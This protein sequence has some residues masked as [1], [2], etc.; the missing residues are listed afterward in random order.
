MFRFSRRWRRFSVLFLLSLTFWLLLETRLVAVVKTDTNVVVAKFLPRIKTKAEPWEIRSQV[1]P[2]NESNESNEG[3]ASIMVQQGLRLYQS[4]K[5]AEAINVWQQA[6]GVISNRLDVALVRNNLA[7]AYRQIGNLNEAVQQWDQAIEIYRLPNNEATQERLAQ[8]LV[9][10]GQTY[11]DLGQQQRAIKLFQ[12]ALEIAKTNNLQ[13]TE[14]AALGGLGNAYWAGGN[15]EQAISACEASLRIARELN[16][17]GKTGKYYIITALNNLGN[18][19]A[20]R[21]ERYRISASVAAIEGDEQA[22]QQFN[23]LAQKDKLAAIAAFQQSAQVAMD[24]LS[25]EPQF[26]D[27]TWQLSE[28]KARLNL[29]RLLGEMAEPDRNL[30]AQNRLRILSILEQVPDSR[31]KVFGLINLAIGKEN[32]QEAARLLGLAIASARNIGDSRS[33]SFA[34]G[35]LGHLYEGS[36]QYSEAM[37]LTQQAQF[38]AQQANAADSLYRWQW[39]AGRIFRVTGDRTR[40]IASYESAIATL[41]SIRGDILVANKDLQFNFRDAVEP[42]YRELIALLLQTG[43]RSLVI[44]NGEESYNQNLQKV[45]NILELLKL[46][47]LQNFF[48]DDCVEIAKETAKNNGDLAG[49]ETGVIYSAILSDRTVMI[50]Q[51]PDGNFTGYPVEIAQDKLQEEIDELRLLLENRATEE[52]LTQAQKIYD[53]LIRPLETD[54]AKL[55]IKTLVF[56]QDGVL[57]KVPMSA[58]HDGQEFLVQKYAIATTPSLALTAS[59]SPNVRNL[60]AL[61]VGLTVEREPFPPLTNVAAEVAEV[62]SLLGGIKLLDRDFTITRLEKEL[63]ANNFPIVHIATHGKF[64]VDAASTFLVGYDGKISLEQLDN[65]LRSVSQNYGRREQQEPVELLT[66]SACQTAAGDNRAAL[67]IAGVAV[68]AGVKSALASL[69]FI[70]DE[71]TVKLIEEFYTQLRQPDVAKAAALQKAQLK[72][73]ASDDYNHPAVWSPFILIGNWR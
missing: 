45:I 46:A 8:L 53:L 35:S 20:S 6:L 40:A 2:G 49:N 23:Q 37:E 7:L 32:S 41:Q 18:A 36:R 11:S 5:I 57:R 31:D 38:A 52:Y 44:G 28:V 9:E 30:I 59:K 48:G 10:Q 1:E 64:G 70:N 25:K 51:S 73:I 69:W 27:Q 19:Y 22:V 55:G 33:L 47:E 26:S 21:G 42:V 34:F 24:G 67:G 39:Q 15:Y 58:L 60:K 56:I 72:L 54:L 63:R 61:A 29:N 16:D 17:S 71:S 12:S 66:L 3:E 43:N 4:G 68:R 62:N 65:L 14:A 13:V 50:L